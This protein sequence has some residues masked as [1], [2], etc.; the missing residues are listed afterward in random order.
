MNLEFDSIPRLG[1]FLLQANLV[2]SL[3]FIATYVLMKKVTPKSRYTAQLVLLAILPFSILVA[4]GLN[5]PTARTVTEPITLNLYTGTVLLDALEPTTGV[6]TKQ[7]SHGLL[8][9]G[10]WI[11]CFIG[12]IG[13]LV[14]CLGF[15]HRLNRLFQ[16]AGDTHPEVQSDLNTI[17]TELG[18]KR[19]VSLFLATLNVSPFSYGFGK[20]KI[21]LPGRLIEKL[22]KE[23]IH[24]ILRHEVHH[25]Q[26]LDFLTNVMQK[27]VRI[28]FFYNPFVHWLDRLIELDRELL[29][30]QAVLKTSSC[31][32]RAYAELLIRVAEFVN[33]QPM[34]SPQVTFHSKQT[35]LRKRLTNMKT[36]YL[37]HPAS[38]RNALT[39]T[40]LIAS[41]VA[42]S[43]TSYGAG[44]EKKKSKKDKLTFEVGPDTLTIKRNG[45]TH[46]FSKNSTEYKQLLEQYRRLI[47]NVEK[48][49]PETV[50]VG[51]T[52][53]RKRTE[54]IQFS[55]IQSRKSE[56]EQRFASSQEQQVVEK[57]RRI[58]ATSTFN[59]SRLPRGPYQGQTK[60]KI[61]DE[62]MIRNRP[63]QKRKTSPE[64]AYQTLDSRQFSQ[65]QIPQSQFNQARSYSKI[66]T[67]PV[68]R[69]ATQNRS[70]QQN[71]RQRQVQIQDEHSRALEQM[72]N[73]LREQQRLIERQHKELSEQLE[74]KHN[75]LKRELDRAEVQ[76]MIAREEYEK[77]IVA[78]RKATE[79]QLK[80][81][82]QESRMRLLRQELASKGIVTG[83]DKDLDIVFSGEG[84][85][86]NGKTYR[87]ELF[88]A[89][90]KIFQLDPKKGSK[91]V[92]RYRTTQ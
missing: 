6:D 19:P 64:R 75:Q 30:D 87:G 69:Q 27:A 44:P 89:A 58:E 91:S 63:A 92:Y 37:S 34:L 77:A 51:T 7:T 47:D 24:L 8:R 1:L 40:T 17:A 5:H 73:Q 14:L 90:K 65:K 15:W 70:E 18:V 55:E 31:T 86:V 68:R 25:I 35:H 82:E 13:A 21:V 49:S 53:P 56:P 42:V 74:R 29:C 32:K 23:E 57:Q 52:P 45:E 78:E 84:L 72:R 36:N 85:E 79:S 62:Q 9:S 60:Q 4:L 2:W 61:R 28:A 26:R 11:L 83:E 48:P 20:P 46:E 16:L 10:I 39:M 50:D 67:D 3:G 54:R 76:K 71:I 22:S 41:F 88:E 38:W 80:A 66:Q 81:R 12:A 33:Q 43:L 59:E